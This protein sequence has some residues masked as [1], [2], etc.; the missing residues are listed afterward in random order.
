MSYLHR[1]INNST[2]VYV[3]FKV[4]ECHE[5]LCL[6]KKD[7]RACWSHTCQRITANLMEREKL[8]F[9]MYSQ[10]IWFTWWTS[11]SSISDILGISLK[12]MSKRQTT[13]ILYV[14]KF[15]QCKPSPCYATVLQQTFRS[16]TII[17]KLSFRQLDVKQ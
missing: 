6:K 17:P 12:A 4:P 9:K 2:M 8:Y 1:P 5:F 3:F 16:V 11:V 13:C 10:L 15:C 14:N 7:R